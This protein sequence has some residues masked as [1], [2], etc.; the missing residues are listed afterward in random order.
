MENVIGCVAM[1]AITFPLSFFLARSCLRGVI[2]ILNGGER[3]D[4]LSSQP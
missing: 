2:R 1:I 3:R 4:V